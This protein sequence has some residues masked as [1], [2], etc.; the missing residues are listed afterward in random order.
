M[1]SIIKGFDSSEKGLEKGRAEPPMQ[2][3]IIQKMNEQT[4]ERVSESDEKVVR[5]KGPEIIM[6]PKYYR[7]RFFVDEQIAMNCGFSIDWVG[8]LSLALHSACEWHVF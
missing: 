3:W 8:L 4:N 5:Q 2:N 1:F 7:K 6:Q